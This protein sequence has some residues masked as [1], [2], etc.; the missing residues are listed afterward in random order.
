[1][2]SEFL[3]LNFKLI[4]LNYYFLPP[5]PIFPISIKGTAPPETWGKI[6]FHF[7]IPLYS[8]KMGLSLDDGRGS[9]QS[10]RSSPFGPPEQDPDSSLYE[11]FL[12]QKIH[13]CLARR[14][15]QRDGFRKRPLDLLK[16]GHL[17]P[18]DHLHHFSL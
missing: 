15:S 17:N 2:G 4:T 11:F 12:Y 7:S 1:M 9:R 8:T 10:P 14:G 3:A 16:L 13:R 5:P 6:P 18:S